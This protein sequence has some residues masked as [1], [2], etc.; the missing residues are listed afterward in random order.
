M[1]GSQPSSFCHPD[2]SALIP[3][4]KNCLFMVACIEFKVCVPKLKPC[5]PQ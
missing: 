5:L 2:G 3:V 1:V 4:A